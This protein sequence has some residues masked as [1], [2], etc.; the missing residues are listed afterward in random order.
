MT[1]ERSR[2]FISYSRNGPAAELASKVAT[3]FKEEGYDVFIDSASI[4]P[5]DTWPIEIEKALKKADFF[6]VFL[7]PKSIKSKFVTVEVK[8]ASKL[9]E[10]NKDRPVI[11]PVHVTIPDGEEIPL[12][13]QATLEG[14]QFSSWNK[15]EDTEELLSDLASIFADN[16]GSASHTSKRKGTIKGGRPS[17]PEIIAVAVA[18]ALLIGLSVMYFTLNGGADMQGEILYPADNAEVTS[19][20]RLTGT[21]QGIPSG[22]TVW[23]AVK[24]EE[25]RWIKESNISSQDKKWAV[26]ITTNEYS[27]QDI[28]IQLLVVDKNGK[29]QISNWFE[30]GLEDDSWPGLQDIEGSTVLDFVPLKIK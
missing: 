12:V 19:A 29:K 11:I 24:K 7:C 16:K 2:I 5:G 3:Y 13:V 26:N 30:K 25:H 6:I 1:Q 28:M 20:F 17:R 8:T 10:K 23:I 27:G 22:Y 9:N 4:R 14:I 18:I 21:L 15:E